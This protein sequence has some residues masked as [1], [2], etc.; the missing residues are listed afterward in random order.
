L[1]RRIAFE[2]I[3]PASLVQPAFQEQLVSVDLEKVL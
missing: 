2:K 1:K 3:L